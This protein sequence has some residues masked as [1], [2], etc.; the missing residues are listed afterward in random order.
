MDE[1]RGILVLVDS[2]DP[3]EAAVRDAG[4]LAVETE[5][6]VV[7]LAVVTPARYERRR[8]AIAAIDELSHF[9][10]SLDQA[11][12]G[13]KHRAERLGLEELRP[14]DVEYTTVVK[15]VARL[16]SLAEFAASFEHVVLTVKP[17]RWLRRRL[18]PSSVGRAL[19]DGFEG[20]LTL[21]P[22]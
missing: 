21:V 3:S 10:Y 13:A 7:L 20:E 4:R 17:R 22:S 5:L 15:Y 12:E 8:R 11:L 6:P 19:V 2:V 9:E 14:L 1:I 18:R 16:D